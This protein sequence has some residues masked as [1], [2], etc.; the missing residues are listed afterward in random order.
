MEWLAQHDPVIGWANRSITVR[1]AGVNRT[2]KPLECIGGDAPKLATMT[3]RGLRKALR[4]GSIEEVLLIRLCSVEEEVAA[5]PSIP[6][7]QEHP[8]VTE[9]L[10]EFAPIF[11]ELPH[12]SEFPAR[13]VTHRIELAAGARPPVAPPLRHQS[14]KDSAFMKAHVEAGIA[15]GQLQHS[16]SPYGS[17][18]LIV[19]KKDGT[20]RVVID[21][22]ALNELT[23]KDKYPL[24]LMDELFDRVHGAKYFTKL[25][26][27]SGFHQIRIALEDREKTAFRTRFGSFEYTVLPMGLC[28]APGTFMRLMNDTFRDMLDKSVLVFLDDILIFSRT[29]EE[30][31]VHLR[32][33][34][35]RL[36]TNKLY[37][38]LS[39]CEFLRDQVEFLGHRIGAAGLAVSPDKIAAVRDWP[40]PRHVKDVQSF[41][42]LAGFYRRFVERYS[43]L[44]LPLTELT[45]KENPFVWGAPQQ[46]AFDALKAALCSAPILIIP[47]PK[48]PYTL[49]CDA[50]DYAIGGTLQQDHGRGLQ[51][52]AYRSRKLTPAEMNYDVRE[53]E[54]M[55]LVDACS[56]WRHYLHSEQP[57]TLL[58]DHDSLKYHKTMPHI[59]GRL[60]RWISKMAEFDYKIEH[61]PGVKNVVADALSRRSDYKAPVVSKA[62]AAPNVVGIQPRTDIKNDPGAYCTDADVDR[63][64]A[65]MDDTYL[66]VA[67]RR[68]KGVARFAPPADSTAPSTRNVI[69]NSRG[70]TPSTLK[71]A[72]VA[73]DDQR[74]RA[75]AAAEETGPPA[76]DRPNPKAS[77]TIVM[78]SHLCTAHTKADGGAYFLELKRDTAVDAA[79][80]DSGQGRWVN[81]PRGTSLTANGEFILYT[82]PGQSRRASVRTTRPIKKG[83]EILVKYGRGYW[84][85][86]LKRK[87]GVGQ[88]KRPR[89]PMPRLKVQQPDPQQAIDGFGMLAPIAISINSSLTDAIIAAARADASY[90]ALAASPP[91][92]LDSVN[93][94]L[95]RG[96]VMVVPN[97]VG[98]RTRLLAEHHDATTGA[99]CGRDKMLLSMRSRLEWNGMATDIEAYVR[100]CDACQRN[101]PSQQATPGLLMPLPIPDRPCQEWT[102][103]MV[104][105]LPRTKRGNDAIQVYV[106]R[107]CK[108]KHFVACTKTASARDMAATFM[109]TVVRAHGVPEAI[110]SDRDPR[111]TGHF[112]AA[113]TQLLGTDLKMSTARHAQTDGQSEREIRTLITALRSFCNERRDDWDEYLDAP[114][115]GANTSVQASTNQCPYQ[116]LYGYVPR[117]PVDV[118]LD[119]LAA[120]R[121]PAA[122][123]RATAI[124]QAVAI[125]RDHLLTAQERQSRNAN[126]HR[127]EASFGIGDR[128]L[129]STDGLELRGAGDK[130]CSRF[131]GPFTVTAVV[132][133]NAYTLDLPPQLRALHPTFNITKLKRYHDGRVAFPS[134][135]QQHPRPPPQAQADSNGDQ[136]F[137][138][139]RVIASRMKGR[140]KEYL[141]SWKG[142]PPEENTWESRASLRGAPQALTDFERAQG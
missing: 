127:R 133:A 43:H 96:S 30:H 31:L 78:P 5:D 104:T 124:R 54:F 121:V 38:K 67:T 23:V 142:Y 135:P 44:A 88:R 111:F 57:F 64:L 125:G 37:A 28:N 48:L 91:P 17:L 29:L 33:V 119:G 70:S 79:R 49:N 32:E 66:Q 81:D 40:T 22:R 101:K 115:L 129:L 46:A 12:A 15:N 7:A 120:A 6:A 9:L 141:V 113:L 52:V 75:K 132:N 63:R 1:V 100:T 80:T 108:V 72:A 50:C 34:L 93:G 139:E 118:A 74:L 26:L 55:A 138:V 53:K 109:H 11:G 69:P 103:D 123:D 106:E 86:H 130:L 62:P 68:A 77:G 39:K 45:R 73:L 10:R 13:G 76:A 42:G 122:V 60:A 56:H 99:H 128:V 19:K 2:I 105:G 59:A 82:P 117:L 47:D 90:A 18:A 71:V 41:L 89:R 83:E 8:A 112:Y 95:W 21:Y 25:D 92:S 94:V 85:Y 134:R 14:Y 16:A 24:P 136:V 3:T 27:R 114:E 116:M 65:A 51:P 110:V 20:P 36:R 137:E 4:H 98:I 84:T 140:A 97:D 87:G 107:L 131:V 35:T 61:I 58:S 126:L 102:T